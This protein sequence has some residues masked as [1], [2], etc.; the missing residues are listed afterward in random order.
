[1]LANIDPEPTKWWMLDENLIPVGVPGEELYD[2]WQDPNQTRN[3]AESPAHAGV[4]ENGVRPAY[5][6]LL[7]GVFRALPHRALCTF[8]LNFHLP[9]VF[10]FLVLDHF[11]SQISRLA[12]NHAPR[13]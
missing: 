4:L 10:P 12:N 13:D 6:H 11:H 1:M 2:L 8:P 7:N 5:Y 3:L 9:S